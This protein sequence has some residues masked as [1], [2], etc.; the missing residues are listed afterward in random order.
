[1]KKPRLI[2]A[3]TLTGALCLANA[4]AQIS[5]SASYEL[6]S[7]EPGAGGGAVQSTGGTS[8]TAEISVGDGIV[9]GASDVTAGGVQTKG[10]FTG[11]LYDPVA[12]QVTGSPTSVNETA[13]TQLTATAVMDDDTTQ[14]LSTSEVAWSVAA[15]PFSGI[16]VNGLA[17]S[18]TVYQDEVG[19]LRGSWQTLDR[20]PYISM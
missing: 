16:T 19:M 12:L 18:T 7:A 15:G 3:L 9:G 4:S 20:P 11:Q 14:P 8:I 5:T 1:M 10:N 13:S 17:T 2:L 6:L